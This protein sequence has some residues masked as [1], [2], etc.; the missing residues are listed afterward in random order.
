MYHRNKF[1]V[2]ATLAATL[3]CLPLLAGCGGGNK[4][5]PVS[6]TPA[7]SAKPGLSGKQKLIALAGA[8]ALYYVFKTYTADKQNA[9]QNVKQAVPDGVQL[10]RSEATGGIY[11][12]DPKTHKAH[13]LTIPNG[14][15]E[16]PEN[17]YNNI[18]G[19]R[20]QWEHIPVPTASTPP[21]GN[22]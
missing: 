18:M 22:M 17:D 8:A 3:M 13:W 7:P 15:I 12:R 21:P 2:V 4:N 14:K 20:D 16:V 5:E 6:E 19:Q 9:P 11:Y 1:R 10:Y